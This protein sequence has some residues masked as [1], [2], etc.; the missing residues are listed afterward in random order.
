MTK[1]LIVFAGGA[2]VGSLA[3]WYI[4]RNKYMNFDDELDCEDES[5]D[6]QTESEDVEKIVRSYGYITEDESHYPPIDPITHAFV[7]K[8]Y[9][10]SPNDF[11]EIDEYSTITITLYADGVLTDENNE[12][13]D[14]D[15]LG[16]ENL[17]HFGEYEEDA[18]HIRC[19]ARK[20]DYEVLLDERTH[21]EVLKTMPTQPVLDRSGEKLIVHE[22][23]EET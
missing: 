1:E 23:D 3:T 4:C 2:L 14:P 15:M 11:G 16:R 18:V 7:E 10:I 12:P 17:N 9:I 13:I 22:R 5:F 8:P 19:D 20:S 21:E 6:E